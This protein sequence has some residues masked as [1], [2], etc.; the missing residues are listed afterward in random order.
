MMLWVVQRALLVGY[1]SVFDG[2][3]VA[4]VQLLRCFE[5]LLG[6]CYEFLHGF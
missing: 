6:G 5:C 2:Q 1:W 3:G 4:K